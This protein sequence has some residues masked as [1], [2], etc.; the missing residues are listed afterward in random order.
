MT[1]HKSINK[2]FT[3][4]IVFLKKHEK[5]LFILCIVVIVLRFLWL[6]YIN[7]QT[8]EISNGIHGIKYWLDSGRYLHGADKIIDGQHLE[9]REKQFFGYMLVIAIT[10][11][12]NLPLISVVILQLLTALA[13]A[14]ALYKIVLK[15]T[16]SKWAGLFGSALFLCNPF[17]TQW[18]LYI[19]TESLYTSFVIFSFWSLSRIYTNKSLKNY[20]ISII[21]LI[22]T[23]FLR[24]NGWILL[25]IFAIFYLI[26]SGFSKKIKLITAMTSVCIFLL[27]A[28]GIGLFRNS[29]QITTPLENL[30]KGVT[31]WNHPE[32]SIEMPQEPDLN[33]D[34]WTEG[35]KYILRHPLSSI[36]LG[37]IRAG[38]TLI[39]IRPYHS[40]KYKI[41]VL[42]W[43]IPA[44]ILAIIGIFVTRKKKITI[45]GLMII[46]GHLFVVALTYAEHDS[47]FDIYIL[48]IIYDFSAVGFI[49]LSREMRK[50]CALKSKTI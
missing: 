14:W 38:Y 42:F 5:V 3:E 19:L 12:L 36:K 45:A 39:H 8:G 7:W 10:K 27:T 20:S 47:R 4:S 31:V 23:M 22:F 18:H 29:I 35:I 11:I 50:L 6:N 21:I 40:A 9:G 15:L 17:I 1:L 24:P 2:I 46:A 26:S 28:A 49:F 32:L 33:K 13:A 25:P 37:A 44:Y 30:Q 41:R 48:P 34:N 16:D 43:I